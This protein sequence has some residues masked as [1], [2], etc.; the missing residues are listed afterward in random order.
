MQN[1]VSVRCTVSACVIGPGTQ[2]LLIM[3]T[4]NCP[5]CITI[6]NLIILGQTIWRIGRD[7]GKNRDAGAPP[8]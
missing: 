6:T 7:P 1:L 8:L 2:R 3:E 5:M 4:R